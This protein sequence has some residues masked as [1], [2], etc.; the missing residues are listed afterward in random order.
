METNSIIAIFAV[1]VFAAMN[2]AFLIWFKHEI[3]DDRAQ[4]IEREVRRRVAEALAMEGAKK[5]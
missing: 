3:K 4:E 1:L 2:G 5:K